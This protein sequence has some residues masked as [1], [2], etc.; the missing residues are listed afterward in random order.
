MP[1]GTL[2]TMQE[3]VSVAEWALLDHDR[4]RGVELVD[5]Q[6]VEGEVTDLVHEMLVMRLAALLHAWFSVRGGLVALSNVGMV[7]GPERGRQADLSVFLS[8]RPERRGPV[9]VAPDVIVEVVSPGAR[10]SRRDRIEKV[11]DYARF[12]VPFY[13]LVDSELRS[14]EVLEL[15]DGRYAHAASAVAG[16]LA[17]PGFEGLVVDVDALF[18]DLD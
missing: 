4:A 10:N 13:W 18:A 7:V 16:T 12:G 17:V 5:G 11:D 15:V 2:V 8:R 1:G 3:T 6:L 9:T 14:L